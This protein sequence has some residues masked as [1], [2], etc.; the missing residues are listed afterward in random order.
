MTPPRFFTTPAKFGA[1]LDKNHMSASELWVGFHKKGSGKPSLTW[2][3]SVD[4][5]LRFGWI[6][7]V[8]KTID[9]TSYMIRFTPRKASSIWSKVNIAKVEAL[10]AQDRM[11]PA[12]LAAYGRRTAERSGIYSFERDAAHFEPDQERVFRKNKKAWEFFQAQPP[13]Y[14]RLVTFRVISAKR[15]ETR[16]RRLAAL[17]E[18]SAQGERIPESLSSTRTA[19]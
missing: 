1:W 14:R 4:E 8:R 15:P 17:I 3:E 6:D 16:E 19:R 5:A 11:A 2:P 7:G 13:Y 18:Y 9:E 12:G 10:I